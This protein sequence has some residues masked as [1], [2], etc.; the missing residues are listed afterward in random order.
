MNRRRVILSPETEDD[1]ARLGDWIAARG[2]AAVADAHIAR[3]AEY[4]LGFEVFAERGRLRE[5]IR[6]GLRIVGFERR[7]AVAFVIEPEQVKILRLL[8]GGRQFDAE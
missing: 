4:C 6:P 7:I 2:G 1:L 5:D 3:I 8:Y